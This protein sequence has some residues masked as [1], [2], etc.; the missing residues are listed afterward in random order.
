MLEH[1]A[2]RQEGRTLI[3]EYDMKSLEK[4]TPEQAAQGVRVQQEEGEDPAP[5]ARA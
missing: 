1:N 5:S 2:T 3:W 4:M